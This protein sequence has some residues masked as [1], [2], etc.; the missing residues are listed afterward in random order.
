M[1]PNELI[2][3]ARLKRA[4]E[5]L[6]TNPQMQITEIAFQNGFSSLRY[7]RHCFKTHFNCT[8]QEYRDGKKEEEQH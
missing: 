3:N 8:P 2:L 4:V 6:K 5:M 1:T 7:F